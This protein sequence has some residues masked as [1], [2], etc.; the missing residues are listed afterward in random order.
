VRTEPNAVSRTTAGCKKIGS[1]GSRPTLR[2]H[3]RTHKRPD[4][5]ALSRVNIHLVALETTAKNYAVPSSGAFLPS[6]NMSGQLIRVNVP[7]QLR[8]WRK[9]LSI[10]DRSG[11]SHPSGSDCVVAV[12]TFLLLIR[13]T[14]R[15]ESS[16]GRS[17][18]RCGRAL[19]SSG[20]C[21]DSH[22]DS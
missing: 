14:L 16:C 6:F 11:A 21:A 2:R 4:V 7:R 22:G 20:M 13:R 5:Q 18:Y 9:S 10:K 8:S 15:V 17:N 19:I 12:V 1:S 3:S